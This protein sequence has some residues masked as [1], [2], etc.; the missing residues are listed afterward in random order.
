LETFPV[1]NQKSNDR[2]ILRSERIKSVTHPTDQCQG[3]A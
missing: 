2:S 3:R 1:N